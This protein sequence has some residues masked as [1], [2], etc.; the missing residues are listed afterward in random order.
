MSVLKQYDAKDLSVARNKSRHSHRRITPPD[1][2]NPLEIKPEE[3]P[4][5][6]S[7]FLEDF[8]AEHSHPGWQITPIEMAGS[9]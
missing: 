5:N 1:D 8:I 7:V 6:R 2:A 9:F 4:T 3:P